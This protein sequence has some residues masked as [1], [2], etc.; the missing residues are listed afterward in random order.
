[1]L[2]RTGSSLLQAPASR[3]TARARGNS[4][5]AVSA[6]CRDYNQAPWAFQASTRLM[7]DVPR[8]MPSERYRQTS[9]RAKTLS[10]HDKT[11]SSFS[12]GLPYCTLNFCQYF[13]R[14]LGQLCR[15]IILILPLLISTGCWD[16]LPVAAD[17]WLPKKTRRKF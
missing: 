7:P 9:L 8:R 1:V 13:V 17:F 15:L 4:A 14:F 11:P 10:L 16:V 12:I 5:S 3:R 2:R 6:R